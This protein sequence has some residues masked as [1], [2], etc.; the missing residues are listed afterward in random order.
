MNTLEDLSR[1]GKDG[2]TPVLK[3][4]K[5]YTPEAPLGYWLFL[6]GA[7][8]L[9]LYTSLDS[10][11]STGRIWPVIFILGLFLMFL[12]SHLET[13]QRKRHATFLE[14]CVF[15][16]KISAELAKRY[17]HLSNEQLT[18]VIQGLRQYFQLC[19]M[20]GPKLVSMPSRVVD[21]AWHEFILLTRPY[22]RFCIYALGNFLHHTPASEMES[23]KVITE[24]LKTAW[25]HACK[26]EEIDQKSPSRLPFLFAIDTALA[27]P[28]GFTHPLENNYATDD[29]GA[30]GSG[31][32]GGCGGCGGGG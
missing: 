12:H 29:A 24:G 15:P 30:C 13:R 26:W 10:F 6:F 3:K 1:N 27:I 9:M 31:G 25:L 14:T 4:P 20:A 21:V 18:L 11:F 5:E 2:L 32:C 22:H 19:N 23:P 16:P 17:P 8:G 7:M 28:D